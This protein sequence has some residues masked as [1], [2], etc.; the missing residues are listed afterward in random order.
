MKHNR[1][2]FIGW[3]VRRA[4]D[5]EEIEVFGD[6]KQLRDPNYIDDVTEAMLISGSD[7]SL[8]GQIF[9][10]GNDQ[11]ISLGDIAGL[12]VRI[13]GGGKCRFV[14]FPEESKKIDIGHY[15]A[16]YGKFNKATGWRPRVSHEDGFKRM[17]DYYMKNKK[18]YWTGK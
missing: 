4:I 14:P 18:Y 2:G 16:S 15:Y 7:D 1:Q 11:T 9:N 3:F 12:L 5:D 10:L 13:R 6:G 17:I 8:N